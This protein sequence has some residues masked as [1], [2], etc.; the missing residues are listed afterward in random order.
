MSANS[1]AGIDGPIT[2]GALAIA[3]YGLVVILA[4]AILGVELVPHSTIMVAILMISLL[5]AGATVGS[6]IDRARAR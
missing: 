6:A 5:A 1:P 3:L 2:G 4:S